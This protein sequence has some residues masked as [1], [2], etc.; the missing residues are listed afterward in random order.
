MLIDASGL[1]AILDRDD[2]DHAASRDVLTTAPLPLRTTWAAMTEASHIASRRLGS[3]GPTGL[4]GLV[5][6]K[7]VTIEELS[8]TAVDS[9]EALMKRYA[10]LPMDLADTTLVYLAAARND[11]AIVT[12]D[13]H[14]HV[15]RV[16]KRRAFTVLP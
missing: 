9:V 10:D 12:H 15:Y 7:A 11:P 5:R 14:F 16:G 3:V 13:H 4:F 1:I 2:P 8:D 6:T